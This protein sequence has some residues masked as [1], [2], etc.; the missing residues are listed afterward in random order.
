MG[1]CSGKTAVQSSI[2]FSRTHERVEISEGGA[3]V[4]KVGGGKDRV[5][6]VET[7]MSEGR[8]FVEFTKEKGDVLFGL[9]RPEFDVEQGNNAH[10]EEDHIFYQCTGGHKYPGGGHWGNSTEAVD[11]DRFGLLLD[12]QAGSLIV[13]KNDKRLGMMAA[14]LEGSY[15]WATVLY[16]KG[17]AVT[18][19]ALRPPKVKGSTQTFADMTEDEAA[20]AIQA[21]VRSRAISTKADETRPVT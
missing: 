14:G 13:F 5:A 11:G 8:H 20:L 7:V 6:A 15:C 2:A 18:I 16:D 1:C 17:A 3:R 21:R 4:L 10:K 19:K 9:I 12:L